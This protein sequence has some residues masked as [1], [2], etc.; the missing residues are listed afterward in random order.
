[1]KTATVVEIQSDKAIAGNGI[2]R[3]EA[4]KMFELALDML[5]PTGVGYDLIG[6]LFPENGTIGIKVNA[7]A[8]SRMSTSPGLVFALVDIFSRL[9]YRKK[10]M[11]IWDRKESEL[12]RAGFKINTRGPGY[13]CFATDTPGVGFSNKLYSY[14]SIGSLVSK[15]QAEICRSMINFPVLKD[16][17]I[18]GLSG[19]LKN[20]YGVIHNP[21]KYHDDMC[22]PYQ[23]DLFS[24]DIIRE[25]QKLAV[26]DA[27]WVQYNGGPGYVARWVAEYNAILLSTDAVA[28]DAVAVNIIDKLRTNAGLKKLKDSG[29]PAV[30]VYTAGKEGLG[31]ADLENIKWV[32][33][34]V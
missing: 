29:R 9:G 22:D 11:I 8:G 30:G 15:I 13:R 12:K 32:K 27:V 3:A 7:L 18:A 10:D 23:A 17:S 14:K 28:L 31:C 2:N 5:S 21:N 6:K 34:K 19:C 24:L 33:R 20:Y 25:K 1:M 4:A 16:H 26:F